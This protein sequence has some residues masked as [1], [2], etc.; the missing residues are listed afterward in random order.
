MRR[1][2]SSPTRCTTVPG[3]FEGIR[4]Y[5]VPTDDDL[6]I[7]RAHE[8]YERWKGSCGILRIQVSATV[9]ELC[10]IT[11]ELMGRNAFHTSVYVRPLAY[12]PPNESA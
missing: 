11:V 8:H 10:A 7:L 1:S 5:W 2:T 9:P 4:A 3:I 12:S 6:F